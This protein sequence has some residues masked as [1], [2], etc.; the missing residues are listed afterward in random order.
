MDPGGLPKI[1]KK[2]IEKGGMQRFMIERGNPL[3]TDLWVSRIYF[4]VLYV[5][6]DRSF[7]ADGGLL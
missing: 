3:S 1:S 4:I 5:V 7:T 2:V 6:A